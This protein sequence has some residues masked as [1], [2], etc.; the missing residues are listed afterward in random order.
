TI[1]MEQGALSTLIIRAFNTFSIKENYICIRDDGW[2]FSANM[3]ARFATT[4]A[5]ILEAQ[6]EASKDVNTP[7]EMLRGL[8]K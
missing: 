2:N 1:C 7:A 4:Q 8:D 6:S 3:T 5:K